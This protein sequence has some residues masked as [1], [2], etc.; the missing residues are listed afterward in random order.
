MIGSVVYELLLSFQLF[1]LDIMTMAKGITSAYLP[2][3]A[4][5]VNEKVHEGLR[6]TMFASY[7]YS[8]HPVCAAAAVKTLEI[9]VRDNVVENAAKVGKYALERLREEF[10]PLPCVGDIRGLGLFI[11]IEIVADKETRKPFDLE[12]NVVPKALKQALAAGLFMRAS[13]S[14]IAPG[15]RLNFCPPLTITT[16]QVDRILDILHPIVADI[17]PV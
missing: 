6:G 15:D 17:K 7:T 1:T 13:S 8:G 11:G 3:G 10:L 12:L 9:Y 14:R 2:F 4:V 5:A 16:E